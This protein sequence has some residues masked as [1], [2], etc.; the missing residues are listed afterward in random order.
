MFDLNLSG[1]DDDDDQEDGPADEDLESSPMLRSQRRRGN[2]SNRPRVNVDVGG[3]FSRFQLQHEI[4]NGL[5]SGAGGSTT[6]AGHL[7]VEDG[8]GDDDGGW[9][10][11]LRKRKDRDI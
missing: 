10:S 3:V 11:K 7:N 5:T 9:R 6:N 2:A 8:N 4:Q 1:E